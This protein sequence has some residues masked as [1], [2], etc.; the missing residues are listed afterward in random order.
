MEDVPEWK[1]W[2]NGMDERNGWDVACDGRPEAADAELSYSVTAF[3][4]VSTPSEAARARR[5]EWISS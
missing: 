3:S 5:R 2:M 4:P 1:E